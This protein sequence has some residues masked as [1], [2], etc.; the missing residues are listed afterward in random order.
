M[1]NNR[2]EDRVCDAQCVQITIKFENLVNLNP[3][4]TVVIPAY[5]QAHYLP[6]ALDS[7]MAQTYDA[8]DVVVVD[9]GS[10]DDT[11]AIAEQYGDAIRYIYQENQGLAAARNTGIRA[12]Q[13][14]MVAFLDSDDAWEP[15]YLSQMMAL[16]TTKPDASVYYCGVRYMDG[17]GKPTPQLGN[18]HVVSPEKM[19]Q[20][21]LRTN[22]LVPS[23]ILARK[24]AL[25]AVDLFDPSFR[26]LQDWELWLRLTKTGHRIVG[27]PAKLVR[28]RIHD[29]SLSTNAEEGRRAV[30]A[31]TRKHFGEENGQWHEASDEKRRAF[32]G[33]YRYCALTTLIREKS[34]S[35]CIPYVRRA[36]QIDPSLARDE[37]FFYEMAL[38]LQ[39]FGYRGTSRF[40]NLTQ[41]AREIHQLL[42]AACQT[43]TITKAVRRDAFGTA[44]FAL[45]QVA[46][47][48]A[49]LAL[50]RRF[51]TKALSFRPG[52]WKN[53]ELTTKLLKSFL[54]AQN[55]HRMRQWRNIL[56]R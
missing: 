12:S 19:H 35:A 22:F 20:T 45:G 30:L 8:F 53:R 46:Y 17:E 10:T 36:L 37:S 28:Y 9:D 29:S 16:A 24:D 51:L 21:L 55:L 52:L 1:G 56:S 49:Q 7:V 44:Y 2:H 15:T 33:A 5:N 4:V 3:M 50:S 26:R 13:A 48:T 25:F 32:G 34:W 18:S 23:T 27:T 6:V 39:P 31:L 14:P 42:K 40:L 11:A 43:N 38:G 41:N 54:G 47:N